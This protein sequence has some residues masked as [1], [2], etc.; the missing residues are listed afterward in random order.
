MVRKKI[1][2]FFIFNKIWIGGLI[3]IINV[4]KCLKELPD[5]QKPHLILF[6]EPD[7][8]SFLKEIEEINYPYFEFVEFKLGHN[9]ILAYIYSFVSQKNFFV[10]N[11]VEAYKLDGLFPL[12]DFPV[13]TRYKEIGRAHV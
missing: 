8:Q 12:N 2:L 13:K 5:S 3:Y 7:N 9:R 6:Y 4:I 10:K 11:I 1:G